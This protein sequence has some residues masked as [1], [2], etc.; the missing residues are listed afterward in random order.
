MKIKRDLKKR[1]RF[2]IRFLMV[3]RRCH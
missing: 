3:E 2:T 1:D